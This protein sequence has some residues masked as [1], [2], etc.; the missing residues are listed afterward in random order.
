MGYEIT[1]KKEAE[2]KVADALSKLHEDSSQ[3]NQ[4]SLV[5]PR[6]QQEIIKSYEKDDKFGSKL[7]NCLLTLRPYQITQLSMGC[8]KEECILAITII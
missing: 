2:N 7:L 8:Y 3:L 6:W 5:P 4:I 1:Y